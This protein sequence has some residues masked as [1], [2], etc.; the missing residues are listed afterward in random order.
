MA[1]TSQD[2]RLQ[3]VLGWVLCVLLAGVFLMAGSIKL[4]SKPVMVEE[5]SRIGLGQWFRY[6]TGAVEVGGAIGLLIPKVSRWAALLLSAVMVGAIIAHLT[7]LHSSPAV[8]IVL[9]VLTLLAAWM[10]R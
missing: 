4:V 7:A 10:R 9:L 5:F 2:G 6:F 3:F 8:V 1:Q